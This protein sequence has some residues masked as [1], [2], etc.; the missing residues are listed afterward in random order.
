MPDAPKP[1]PGNATPPPT[2]AM[3]PVKPKCKIE[4]VSPDDL[5]V[6]GINEL[7]FRSFTSSSDR[8]PLSIDVPPD[9]LKDG[10]NTITGSYTNVALPGKNEATV[11]YKVFLEENEVVTVGYKSEL[12]AQNFTVHFKDSFHLRQKAVARGTPSGRVSS[13]FDEVMKFQ[14]PP[15][16]A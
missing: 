7:W 13:R 3:K 16:K 4:I 15:P 5:L 1:A 9:V 8:Y 10:W 2:G 14:S 6:V 11:Q 12:Q